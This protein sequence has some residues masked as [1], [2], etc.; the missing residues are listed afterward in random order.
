[1]DKEDG[2]N[3]ARQD[4]RSCRSVIAALLMLILCIT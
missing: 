3:E 4:Q 1:M 2:M